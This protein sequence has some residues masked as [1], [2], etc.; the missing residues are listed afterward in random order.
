[1]VRSRAEKEQ[2][3][4]IIQQLE[5]VERRKAV[6][7]EEAG[8]TEH[9]RR[10][11]CQNPFKKCNVIQL[12]RT[13]RKLRRRK[14]EAEVLLHLQEIE[15]LKAELGEAISDETGYGQF[16]ATRSQKKFKNPFKNYVM[17]RQ[18]KAEK[19]RARRI[20]EA[21]VRKQ[22]QDIELAKAEY[23]KAELAEPELAEDISGEAVHYE[24][25]RHKKPRKKCTNLCKNYNFNRQVKA[26][27]KQARRKE[28]EQM[29]QRLRDIELANNAV[30][31]RDEPESEE[32][33]ETPYEHLKE[34]QKPYVKRKRLKCCKKSKHKKVTELNSDS[35]ILFGNY[36]PMREEEIIETKVQRSKPE[37]EEKPVR[38]YYDTS[39]D[40]ETYKPRKIKRVT[41]IKNVP[42]DNTE[43][44]EAKTAKRVVHF[45]PEL[46][47]R[48]LVFKCK[49][50]KCKHLYCIKQ[51]HDLEYDSTSKLTRKQ[52][53]ILN[54][55]MSVICEKRYFKKIINGSH[56]PTARQG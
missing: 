52:R 48:P 8:N 21:E 24:R 33:T 53:K 29:R 31:F 37:Y 13:E 34:K 47:N 36:E 42:D 11:L 19:K 20:R 56:C 6:L 5:E 38:K 1:M 27:K 54:R 23:A 46:D 30:R 28:E 7:D 9:K 22:L 55:R 25:Y 18:I 41:K 2:L 51:R 45:M 49:N 12:I 35:D 10:F 15:S 50:K 43:I 3:A 44:Y 4:E 14:R 16:L 17:N 39:D 26:E 40:Y 32:I